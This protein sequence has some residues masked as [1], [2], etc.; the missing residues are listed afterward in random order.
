M[1]RRTFLIALGG[2]ITA[3]PRAV[4]AQPGKVHTILWVSTEAQPDPFIGG[5]RDGMRERGYIEGQNLAFT[6]RYTPG[7]PG[8][9]RAILPELLTLPADLIV[10]SGPAIWTMKA[11]TGR[12]VLFAISGDPVELGIAESLARPGRNFTGSTFMSLDVAQKRVELLKEMV[13]GLRTL[14]ALSNTNHPGER[15]EHD[16]TRAMAEALSVRMAYVPFSS[17][18][19]LEGALER[20][21]ASGADALLVFPDGITMVHRARIAAFAKSHRLPSMFGWREYCDAGGLAS[22]GANQRATYFHLAQ[23]AD[24]LLRGEKPGSLPIQRAST[25][26]LVLNL[27]TARDLSLQVPATLLARADDLIE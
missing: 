22:Y 18:A 27:R 1:R 6:L 19:E 11:A 23:Y 7:D 3:W 24:R 26:E 2:S 16:A 9:L 8:A 14:A 21:R 10:S 5:F 15:S 13:P 17:A 4:R 20:V 25:F 12:T